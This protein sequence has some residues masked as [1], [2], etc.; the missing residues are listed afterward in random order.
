[1]V[2]LYTEELPRVHS[3][4]REKLLTIENTVDWQGDRP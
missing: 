4:R 1:V 3:T 2:L